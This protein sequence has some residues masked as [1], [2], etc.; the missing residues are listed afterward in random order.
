M[1][2]LGSKR[3]YISDWMTQRWVDFTGRGVDLASDRW[4]AGPT[5]VIILFLLR[6]PKGSAWTN[7]VGQQA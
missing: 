2:W 4:L 6:V 5:V 7:Q 3:G 1:I